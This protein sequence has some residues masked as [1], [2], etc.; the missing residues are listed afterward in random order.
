MIE[1]AIP[2]T[3][4]CQKLQRHPYEQAEYMGL[5]EEKRHR[6]NAVSYLPD[7]KAYLWLKSEMS[8]AIMIETASV[9]SP[10]AVAG[11]SQLELERFIE[12]E[13]LGSRI[14]REDL[15]AQTKK[16]QAEM[17]GI[18]AVEPSIASDD[19]LHSLEEEY[20]KKSSRRKSK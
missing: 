1:P 14:R 6:L 9:P 13:E 5:E 11:C 2:L 20:K 8:K 12:S 3:G 7:R 17:R 18:E 4:N 16:R 15:L 10:Y 19:L